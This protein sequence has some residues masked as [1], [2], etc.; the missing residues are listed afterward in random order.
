MKTAL[1]TNWTQEDF[2]GYWDGKA[3]RIKAGQ[4]IWM[5]DYLAKHFAKHLTN[6]ELVRTDEKGNLVHKNGDKYTSPKKPDQ[7]PV[8]TE[9]FEK[10]YQE[11]KMEDEMGSEK[12]DVDA[13]IDSANKN[14]E[15]ENSPKEQVKKEEKE[16]DPTKPQTVVSPDFDDDEEDEE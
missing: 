1:F 3:K 7:V 12:D 6:R 5:P 8:Y 2:I 11:E 14:R 4:S 13:L 16:Q 10:A 15:K 9:L